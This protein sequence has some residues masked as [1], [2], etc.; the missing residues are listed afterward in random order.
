MPAELAI[1]AC[2]G[3]LLCGLEDGSIE[4]DEV[5]TR[6]CGLTTNSAAAMWNA[7]RHVLPQSVWSLFSGCCLTAANLLLYVLLWIAS[8]QT[9]WLFTTWRMLL[10]ALPIEY[11]FYQGGATNIDQETRCSR[12]YKCWACCGPR[13]VLPDACAPMLFTNDSCKAFENA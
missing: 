12:Y 2:H 11:L 9:Q 4:E 5:V 1:L 3:R 7:L 8:V 6:P 10:R 13:F